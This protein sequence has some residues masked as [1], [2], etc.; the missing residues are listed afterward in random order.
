MQAKK[1]NR[2]KTRELLMQMLFS[3]ELLC[4]FTDELKNSF[5]SQYIDESSDEAYFDAA[6]DAY[7]NHNNEI[8]ETI[9]E[10]SSGWKLERISKVDLSIL[11]LSISEMLCL[12]DKDI[13]PSVSISEAVRLAKTFGT[14]DSGKFING[15][16]GR[17][18]RERCLPAEEK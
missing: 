18:Y 3:M 10:F 13:P 16:L 17:I 14:E 4:D 1:V 15:I 6:F 12:K 2:K 5:R 11:R 7:I 8:D 9:E